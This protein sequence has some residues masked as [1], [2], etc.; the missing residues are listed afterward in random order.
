MLTAKPV[1]YNC[2]HCQFETKRKTDY[3]RHISSLKHFRKTGNTI[4]VENVREF[5]CKMCDFSTLIASNYN[6][7]LKSSKHKKQVVYTNNIKDKIHDDMIE[8]KKEI[9]DDYKEEIQELTHSFANEYKDS[10]DD[11]VNEYGNNAKEIEYEIKTEIEKIKDQLH[12]HIQKQMQQNASITFH[13][14][15]NINVFLNDTCKNALDINEFIKRIVVGVRELELVVNKGLVEGLTEI[16]SMSLNKLSLSE[17]PIHCTDV[18]RNIIHTKTN[19]EWQKDIG[20]KITN[21]MIMTVGKKAQTQIIPWQMQNP[22]YEQLDSIEFNKLYQISKTIS[23]LYTDKPI[24][25]IIK[26]MSQLTYINKKEATL[27]MNET[28]DSTTFL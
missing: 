13:N 1:I 5:V 21:Q 11:I 7:H 4:E 12:D 26:N 17:R 20:H 27:M 18:K 19:N 10:L 24:H 25:K 8:I 15:F 6:R 28:H 22:K 23:S 14:N 3:N 16:F 9:T 2:K